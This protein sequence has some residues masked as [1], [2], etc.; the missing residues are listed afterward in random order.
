M[1]ALTSPKAVQFR[2]KEE[3]G[4]LREQRV[5]LHQDTY[6]WLMLTLVKHWQ[7]QECHSHDHP[8]LDLSEVTHVSLVHAIL[9]WAVSIILAIAVIV[10]FKVANMNLGEA[11]SD[12]HFQKMY[13][14]TLGRA[15]DA[16]RAAA[17]DGVPH[18]PAD[19]LEACATQAKWANMIWIYYVT[20]VFW[21]MTMVT[22]IKESVWLG[23]HIVGVR[24]KELYTMQG[25]PNM[26]T[27][28]EEDDNKGIIRCLQSWQ[29]GLLV[30]IV[31]AFR[32]VIS[33]VLTYVGA[34]YLIMS[35]QVKEMV[36]K[37]VALQF[38][39][40]MDNNAADG[41]LTVGNIEELHKVKMLTAYGHPHRDSLWDRGIGGIVYLLVISVMFVV[42]TDFVYADL[43]QFRYACSEYHERFGIKGVTDPWAA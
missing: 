20:L 28:L 42:L 40:K 33:M 22:E 6:S 31:P 25:V 34:E 4:T 29:K 23:L 15:S 41:L 1:P 36:L 14:L 32:I 19:L 17:A 10:F 30:F 13:H 27:L 12:E 7:G 9:V 16:L 2:E 3:L 39:I 18:T 5:D 37:T 26:E 11:I 38:V 43:F 8:E 24:T 35:T 21:L